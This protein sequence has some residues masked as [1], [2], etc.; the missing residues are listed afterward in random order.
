MPCPDIP[1]WAAEYI[2]IPY[3]PGGRDRDGI[4]CWGLAS[5][6]WRERLGA[7][8]PPYD[9]PLW[10]AGADVIEVAGAAAGYAARFRS[11][12]PGQERLGDGVLFRM[13]GHPM[14]LALVLSPGWMLHI[15][16]TTTSCIEPYFG[17]RWQKRIIAFYRGVG[18]QR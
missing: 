18:W 7:D 10:E 3:K 8:L 13:L 17:F 9:G 12:D 16:D 4:D 6:V 14:H 2:G 5:L 1:S 15:D 11:V